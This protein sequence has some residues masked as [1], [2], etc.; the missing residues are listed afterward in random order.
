M[1]LN[2]TSPAVFT[3]RDTDGALAGIDNLRPLGSVTSEAPRRERAVLVVPPEPPRTEP[4]PSAE[5]RVDAARRATE[6]RMRQIPV[7]ID[8]RSG[9]DRRALGRRQADQSSVRAV[10]IRA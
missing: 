9:R 6:R 10:D 8:T 1:R 2:T 7:L 5:R 4:R 3:V